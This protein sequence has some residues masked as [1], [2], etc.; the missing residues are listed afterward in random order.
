MARSCWTACRPLRPAL[1]ALALYA[2]RALRDGHDP[3]DVRLP[4]AWP[5]PMRLAIDGQAAQVGV[6][7]LGGNRYRVRVRRRTGDADR[8]RPVRRATRRS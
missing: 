6:S 5:L 3:T 2:A 7:A 4:L 1:A 8:C